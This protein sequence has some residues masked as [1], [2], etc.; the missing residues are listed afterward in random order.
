MC[1]DCEGA[2]CNP[3]S[4][5]VSP[6]LAMATFTVAEACAATDREHCGGPLD[7]I[8]F[9]AAGVTGEEFG[10]HGSN[11]HCWWDF[12]VYE[13]PNL[14]T[15]ARSGPMQVGECRPYP[16]KEIRNAIATATITT[17]GPHNTAVKRTKDA[18]GVMTTA[19]KPGKVSQDATQGYGM[20]CKRQLQW[21]TTK[22]TL[23]SKPTSKL[24]YPNHLPE[25]KDDDEMGEKGSMPKF[26][27]ECVL[28]TRI[29]DLFSDPMNQICNNAISAW[30]NRGEGAPDANKIQP[31]SAKVLELNAANAAGDRTYE[32]PI[33]AY[34]PV[35]KLYYGTRR[36]SGL[37][38]CEKIGMF[39]NFVKKNG[40]DFFKSQI[41]PCKSMNENSVAHLGCRIVTWNDGAEGY[42]APYMPHHPT[43]EYATRS[44]LCVSVPAHALMW[45]DRT[46]KTGGMTKTIAGYKNVDDYPS[47]FDWFN[48]YAQAQKGNKFWP[49]PIKNILNVPTVQAYDWPAPK[50]VYRKDTLNKKGKEQI[51]DERCNDGVDTCSLQN[52]PN[53]KCKMN[54]MS[55]S[56][57]AGTLVDSGGNPVPNGDAY[58]IIGGAVGSGKNPGDCKF[59]RSIAILIPGVAFSSLN[60]NDKTATADAVALTVALTLRPVPACSGT[61]QAKCDGGNAKSCT[62]CEKEETAHIKQEVKKIDSVVLTEQTVRVRS[63]RAAGDTMAT[64]TFD[65]DWSVFEAKAQTLLNQ[66]VN[67]LDTATMTFDVTVS[68]TVNVVTVTS[69]V[70][71]TLTPGVCTSHSIPKGTKLCKDVHKVEVGNEVMGGLD[72]KN[73][74]TSKANIKCRGVWIYQAN[75]P[76]WT[77]ESERLTND[78]ATRIDILAG[79]YQTKGLQGRPDWKKASENPICDLLGGVHKCGV[80]AGGTGATPKLQWAKS[81]RCY[82]K[83][84]YDAFYT[85]IMAKS[86]CTTVSAYAKGVLKNTCKKAGAI[87]AMTEFVAQTAECPWRHWNSQSYVYEHNTKVNNQGKALMVKAVVTEDQD[88]CY[89]SP[90]ACTGR[91]LKISEEKSNIWAGYTDF[92]AVGNSTTWNP[93]LVEYEVGDDVERAPWENSANMPTMA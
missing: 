9:D 72:Q 63:R 78:G 50:L 56:K 19:L 88:A 4:G 47:G 18:S 54:K 24:A 90:G 40:I 70:E 91:V 82:L 11:G 46:K 69:A 89:G 23:V 30:P 73:T 12:T 84:E 38:H 86:A 65:N 59:T 32:H 1:E 87:E 67:V 60:S 45:N 27:G 29:N 61:H 36:A 22:D 80:I 42:T 20:W 62:K 39:G 43:S 51:C 48:P 33:T 57:P 55:Q 7:A 44:K 8:A 16:S 79:M 3:N 85:Q 2:A 77:K 6:A 92:L 13:T 5:P 26:G 58:P 75:N 68:G 14:A 15:Q 66:Q 34:D 28:R 41:H 53:N 25:A 35:S 31:L 64:V 74:V 10:G 81:G 17:C 71:P 49:D 21:E 37:D 83:D 93:M 76:I 52:V